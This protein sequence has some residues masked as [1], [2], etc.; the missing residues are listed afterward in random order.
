MALTPAFLLG[1][2]PSGTT[3][4]R[5][6]PSTYPQAAGA[7]TNASAALPGARRRS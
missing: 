5:R 4:V 6:V 7:P 3:L 1:T 2:P